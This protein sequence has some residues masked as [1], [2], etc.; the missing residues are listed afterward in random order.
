MSITTNIIK[1]VYKRLHKTGKKGRFAKLSWSRVKLLKHEEDQLIKQLRI[2]D[3]VM[4]YKKPYEVMHTYEEIFER[5]IYRF[6]SSTSSPL[7]VDC[8]ANIGMSVLYFKAIYPH[9]KI[10]AFE[11]DEDN[12][13]MLERNINANRLS[14]IE[15]IKA[16]VWKENTIL[17]FSSSGSQGSRIQSDISGAREL[18]K[19]KA[20]RLAD[21]LS[22]NEIDFLKIDI[23]GAEDAV[24]HDCAPYLHK[25]KNLFLEY[26]GTVAET[27]KLS[28]ILD[29]LSKCGF[30]T[31]IKMAADDLDYPFEKKHTGYSFDVQLNLFCYR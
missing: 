7:I 13:S 23:E 4:L 22:N 2:N 15:A 12:Y 8:G 28:S 24:M 26:H 30:K 21:I 1:G 6:L 11:P 25:V 5:E 20:V 18:V 19:V 16:A 29:L 14:D 3:Q 27:G 10:M 9:A 17:E 31:Y